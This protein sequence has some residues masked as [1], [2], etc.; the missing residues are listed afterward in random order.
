MGKLKGIWRDLNKAGKLF[1][2]ALV[3]ILAVILVNYII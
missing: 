2:I 3:V 1:I